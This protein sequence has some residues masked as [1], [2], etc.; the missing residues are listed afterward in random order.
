MILAFMVS[1][2]LDPGFGVSFQDKIEALARMPFK[3]RNLKA[4]TCHGKIYA[5][6]GYCRKTEEKLEVL[7]LEYDPSTDTWMRKSDLPTGRSNLAL[8]A[9]KNRIYAI[10]GDRFQNAN[11]VYDPITDT[12]ERLEPLPI[13]TQHVN[14]VALDGKI[15][16]IGGLI[17]EGLKAG[18]RA[19]DWET[20]STLSKN[21]FV[22]DP[23]TDQWQ[24]KSPLPTPRHGCTLAPFKKRIFVFGGAGDRHEIW[25]PRKTVESYDPSTDT[26]RTHRDMPVGLLEAGAV[27]L[28]GKIFLV[29]GQTNKDDDAKAMNTVHE[30]LPEEDRWRVAGTLPNPVQFAGTTVFDGY[31]YVIGG[32]DG[33]FRAYDSLIRVDPI[34]FAFARGRTPES[35]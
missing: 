28:N 19:V 17:Y 23:E 18:E 14:A 31:V 10:G 15:Y 13:P 9:C 2:L 34:V 20:K 26:W 5:V 24:A 4:V 21:T 27:E 30:F 1:L 33:Q 25:G 3:V 29:G 16:V 35:T 12:W 22:Y 11:E 32:C 6:G 8:V 7:N